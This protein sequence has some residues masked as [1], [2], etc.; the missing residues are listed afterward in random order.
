MANVALTR[1]FKKKLLL[2]GMGDLTGQIAQL[3]AVE[4]KDVEIGFE[5]DSEEQETDGVSWGANKKHRTSDKVKI[6]GKIAFAG[7][8]TAGVPPA[9]REL[10]LM[11]GH[12][13][14]VK[15]TGEA[16]EKK[17]TYTPITENIQK[18]TVAFL[19]DGEFHIGKEAQAEIKL[20][21]NSGE[22]GY[23]DFEISMVGGTIPT[24]QPSGLRTL[25]EGYQ[26]PKAINFANTPK[27][28]IG[29]RDYPMKGFEYTTGNEITALDLVNHQSAMISDRKPMVKVVV[30]APALSEINLYQKAWD[31]VEMP[32]VLEH[33]TKAGEKISLNFPNVSLDI[34]KATDIDGALGYEIECTAMQK[35]NTAPYTIIFS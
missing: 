11:S 23:W 34:P 19:L 14:T 13:E 24:T 16:N 22:I 20:T 12:S 3:K 21:A 15:N 9:Y 29:G 32:L 7:S 10:F 5:G 6:T 18:G 17:V 2:L 30:G 26:T 31:G 25:V 1:K 28:Q 33:G 27:F 4:T 35:G 8:G